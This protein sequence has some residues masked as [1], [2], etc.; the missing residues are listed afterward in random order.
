MYMCFSEE[1]PLDELESII[2]RALKWEIMCDTYSSTMGNLGHYT[3][4]S[5]TCSLVSRDK[6]GLDLHHPRPDDIPSPF[7]IADTVG[8]QE[9]LEYYKSLFQSI[10]ASTNHAIRYCGVGGKC[11]NGYRQHSLHYKTYVVRWDGLK[12]YIQCTCGHDIHMRD[13]SN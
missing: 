10:G 11:D 5:H 4:E 6:L 7:V 1:I 12:K 2:L 8:E 13:E 9:F 3:E